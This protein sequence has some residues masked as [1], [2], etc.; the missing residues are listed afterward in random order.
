MN[1]VRSEDCKL[2]TRFVTQKTYFVQVETIK[3]KGK[4]I[5]LQ[6]WMGPDGSRWLRLPD[7]KIDV[8]LMR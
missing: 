6:A 2:R 8:T 3:G 1:T 7:F 5:P 4:A